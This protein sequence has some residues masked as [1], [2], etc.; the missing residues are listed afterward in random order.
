MQKEVGFFTPIVYE[1]PQNFLQSS[2]ERIGHY[3]YLGGKQAKVIATN[4]QSRIHQTILIEQKIGG[5][6]ILL[7]IAKI[8]SF[9]TIVIPLIMLALLKIAR[10]KDQFLLAQTSSK[11]QSLPQEPGAV[12]ALMDTFTRAWTGSKGYAND[13]N[14]AK[15]LF[16]PQRLASLLVSHVE[17]LQKPALTKNDLGFIE[18]FDLDPADNPQIYV[19][20]DLHGDLKSLIANLGALQAEGL[21]DG[22]YQ[23][24][25]GVHLVFLG[26]YCDRGFNG[27]QILELLMLLRHE[28]PEQ[29]HL[30]RGNHE[31][32]QIN[33]WHGGSDGLLQ[34]MIADEKSKAALTKFYESM[35]LSVY[36][37]IH[38]EHREYVQF[39]H[40]LFEPSFDPARLLDQGASG[41]YCVVPKSRLLSERIKKIAKN[42]GHPHQAS[43]KRIAEIV[44]KSLFSEIEQNY[45][46]YNWADVLYDN[47]KSSTLTNLAARGYKLNAADIT[48][49]LTLSSEQH[50]V[51]LIFRGHQHE[52]KELPFD[53]KVL[54]ATLPVGVDCP[55]Y[56]FIQ[57]DKAYILTPQA[58]IEDWK[59]KQ[60]IRKKGEDAS[61]VIGDQ[62][63][64]NP[65]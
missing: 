36:F 19:R 61:A 20:A 63:V 38:G 13:F 28:N 15:N 37:S 45:T 50:R 1:G 25:K 11:I 8:I 31:D 42:S 59:K 26:D 9:A 60:I 44:Q 27:T 10:A 56:R 52:F 7:T 22:N 53:N 29:V 46:L 5:K 17:S 12:K 43:A 33:L 51:G 6:Q 62:P 64:Q 39:T 65:D 54:V 49:Y 18:K 3:F 4:P 47:D 41:E 14:F 40:G 2:Q 21:L 30:I 55:A 57:D 23:C 16:N 48:H 34:D 35:P 32:T 58:K 24:K